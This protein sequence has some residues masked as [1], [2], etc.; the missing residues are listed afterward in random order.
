[1][2]FDQNL[3]ELSKNAILRFSI[4][5]NC[6]LYEWQFSLFFVIFEWKNVQIFH[7]FRDNC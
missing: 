2:G 7:D 5:V 4:C 6:E 1:M 3:R